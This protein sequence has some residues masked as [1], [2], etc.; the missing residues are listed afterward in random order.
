MKELSLYKSYGYSFM[1]KLAF[2]FVSMIE[3]QAGVVYQSMGLIIPV[4]TSSTLVL[5]ATQQ[6]ASLLEIARRLDIPHQLAAQRVK[7]LLKLQVISA[8]KDNSDK[9]RT[10]YQLTAMGQQQHQLLL[11]YLQHADKVFAALT[12]EL[13]VDLMAVLTAAN[14]SF[15]ERPLTSRIHQGELHHD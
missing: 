12:I 15:V 9:R 5:I 8:D 6:K 2:D 11:T 7:T 10:N 13:G 3:K 4:I 1:P 14:S